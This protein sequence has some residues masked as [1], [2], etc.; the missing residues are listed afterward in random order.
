[1]ISGALRAGLLVAIPAAALFGV[2]AATAVAAPAATTCSSTTGSSVCYTTGSH[3][4]SV[5]DTNADGWA[6]YAWWNPGSSHSQPTNR[7]EFTGGNG[8]CGSY[9]VT[10]SGG[11]ISFQACRDVRHDPD[12]CGSW[13][14]VT[15]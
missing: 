4:L 9:P 14:T 13:Q 7:A 2:G 3:H 5:C 12:N 1:M 15:Y 11:K 8:H 10:G 6:P